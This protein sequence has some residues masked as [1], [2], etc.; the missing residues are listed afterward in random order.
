MAV[1]EELAKLSEARFLGMYQA[2]SQQ[3]YGPLD[4]EIAR[5]L[6]FRPHAIKKL[7]METRARR[8][9]ALVEGKQSTDLC[10]EFFGTYL[11]RT[12]KEL[13]TGFLDRTGVAHQDG[14]IED[15][16]A[17]K[18]D[19]AKLAEAIRELDSKFDPEDVTLYLALCVE[20][21]PGM[22]ELALAWKGR[23]A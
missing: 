23:R 9:R 19:P 13:V 4:H 15:I 22:S 8:A 1:L 5:A 2:L 17:K 3:G 14:M 21:W 20:Q 16:D 7:P 12:K 18:P 10:Y 11:V 6:K